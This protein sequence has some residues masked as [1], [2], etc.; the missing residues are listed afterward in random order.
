MEHDANGSYDG[1]AM[2]R[3]TVAA[4]LRETP[5][6]GAVV[7]AGERGLDRRIETVGVLDVGELD[8][9]RPDQL[10]LSNAHPLRALNL[11]RLVEQLAEAR[12]SAFGVKPGE[13]WAGLPDDLVEACETRGLP[14]LM[15]PPGRF[16]TIVNPV[17]EAIVERQGERLR[18]I[19]ELH[20]ALTRAALGNEP[21]PTVTATVARVLG[22]PVAVFDE[23]GALVTGT[24]ERSLWS[25]PALAEE[26]TA[27]AGRGVVE[28][29]GSRYLLAPISTVGR[30]Y[31]A[32]CATG[33]IEDEGFARAAL[34]QAAVV[35]GMQLVGRER[36][37]AVHRKFE[38][39][40]LAELA[41]RSLTPAEARDRAERLGWPRSAPY[42]VLLVSRRPRPQGGPLDI[43]RFSLDDGSADA[44][45]RALA[46]VLGVRRFPRREGL[47]VVVH[48]TRMQDR[49]TAAE[50]VRR[51]LAS[52]RGVPWAARELTIGVSGSRR[53]V[54]DLP[55]ALREAMLALMTSSRLR[56]G[57]TSVE[58][59]DDLGLG[60][61]LALIPE[62]ERLAAM[63]QDALGPLGEPDLPGR[64][65]LLATLAALVAHNMRLADAAK[66]LYFHYN[67][68]RH[69]LARLR[70]LLGSRIEEPDGR[71]SLSLAL[72]ALRIVAVERPD[73]TPVEPDAGLS[74]ERSSARTRSRSR[75]AGSRPAR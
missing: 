48:L 33:T 19:G 60:R 17:L 42:L 53:E 36:V 29:D 7:A 59:F 10:V 37:E 65:D 71:L 30:R 39:Q 12:V 40:L 23:Q 24:G 58:H 16:E 31:G 13:V 49:H 50:A 61:L 68:V 11:S 18:R 62:V 74:G 69:R 54:T 21:M 44:F 3:L 15:L 5:L 38:H 55:D 28:V 47:G 4:A 70:K 35:C 67:T 57:E 2:G 14:L 32:L 9:L 52:A 27:M 22:V 25:A 45:A 66:D 46:P 72:V 34:A 64:Q 56:T 41:D 43:S 20:D 8:A 75:P 73:L 6:S 51:R 63:A 26:A 1:T